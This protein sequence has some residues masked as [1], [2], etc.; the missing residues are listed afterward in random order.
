MLVKN[1]D[2]TE[3]NFI[4]N[5]IKRISQPIRE[6]ISYLIKKTPDNDKDWH[7][8]KEMS[9]TVMYRL[10]REAFTTIIDLLLKYYNEQD[11]MRDFL[12]KVYLQAFLGIRDPLLKEAFERTY[13][14]PSVDDYVLWGDKFPW[15]WAEYTFFK[16]YE[17]VSISD[18]ASLFLTIGNA[19]SAE[20]FYAYLL[21]QTA[22]LTKKFGFPIT[23]NQLKHYFLSVLPTISKAFENLRFE[24][25]LSVL[26]LLSHTTFILL[27]LRD[28]FTLKFAISE[29]IELFVDLIEQI[30]KED[31]LY[32]TQAL[33]VSDL[34]FVTFPFVIPLKPLLAQRIRDLIINTWT[35]MS[36]IIQ[37]SL[38][39]KDLGLLMKA[40]LLAYGFVED[41]SMIKVE[42]KDSIDI[43]EDQ[44]V[45]PPLIFSFLVNSWLSNDWKSLEEVIEQLGSTN[46]NNYNRL[47]YYL[48][49]G[50]ILI[51]TERLKDFSKH[52]MAFYQWSRR[53]D[54]ALPLARLFRKMFVLASKRNK[55]FLWLEILR[56]LHNMYRKHSLLINIEFYVPLSIFI[57]SK[58]LQDVAKEKVLRRC[59]ERYELN[60][61]KIP[62][63]SIMEES[64]KKKLK[65]LLRKCIAE[66]L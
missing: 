31:T 27:L 21:R 25:S 32:K 5:S 53:N 33:L 30:S 40:W 57:H 59:L 1:L 12:N 38:I 4:L 55:P 45:Y 56:E 41:S 60:I 65:D 54:F 13:S 18:P 63:T 66:I 42:F 9:K 22:M 11:R 20:L 50:I 44:V 47:I 52:A 43:S 8:K 15:H 16:I 46:N 2:K 17:D 10:R 64:A 26:K 7:K 49:K 62:G 35:R 29:T 48:V 58:H 24:C 36:P 3:R 23:H 51:E 34:V 19:V 6:Y 28:K 14:L 37:G 39:A 61:D